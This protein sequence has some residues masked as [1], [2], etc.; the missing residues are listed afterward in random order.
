[1]QL[2]EMKLKVLSMIEEVEAT[3]PNYT[4]DPDITSKINYV[5]NQVMFELSRVKKIPDYVEIEVTK[6][7]LIT[8]EDIANASGYEVYQLEVVRG[9]EF[10]YKAHGTIIK[11]KEDGKLEID[12]FRYPTRID[13]KTTDTYEFELSDDVLE[14]M[15]YGVAGDLLKS[16]VSNAYGNVYSE[17]YESMKQQLDIRYNTGSVEFCEG[18]VI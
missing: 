5:I 2:K 16:D 18:V 7:S 12:H 13:E 6:D 17:R 15:P 8:F 1:M 11:C 9:I 14:I 4:R 3:N 10:E